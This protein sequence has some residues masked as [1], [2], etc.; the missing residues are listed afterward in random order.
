MELDR[1]GGTADAV[2]EL[3]AAQ[4]VLFRERVATADA[5]GLAY[6]ESRGGVRDEG[7]GKARHVTPEERGTS[8]CLLAAE[9]LRERQLTR[10]ARIGRAPLDGDAAER[11]EDLTG[12]SGRDEV[13]RATRQPGRL[14]VLLEEV[15]QREE[16]RQCR[17]EVD[18]LHVEHHRGVLER[19]ALLGGGAGGER[20]RGVPLVSTK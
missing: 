2:L 14:E 15:V 4:D 18:V 8:F 3:P 1:P 9:H 17:L 19:R 11:D 13:P 12:S 6:A 20:E 16:V 5:P 7:L 10:I